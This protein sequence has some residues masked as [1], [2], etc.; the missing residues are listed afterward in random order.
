MDTS[1]NGK[2]AA[3]RER[4]AA[5]QVG[6]LSIRA[7][8]GENGQPEHM[9]YCWRSRLGLSPKP[10]IKRRGR[11]IMQAGFAEVVVVPSLNRRRAA[12][13]ARPPGIR[14]VESICLRLHG[15]REL[16]LPAS[17]SDQR[18]ATLVHLIE[19]DRDSQ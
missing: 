6:G 14:A 9:F 17:L 8:C 2:A 5:Q 3:W 10:P 15:G 7:W 19:D 4:I 16:V 1:I 11:R 12:D 18:L 13:V